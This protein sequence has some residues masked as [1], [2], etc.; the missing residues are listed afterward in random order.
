MSILE[1]ISF[2]VYLNSQLHFALPDSIQLALGLAEKLDTKAAVTIV[3]NLPLFISSYFGGGKPEINTKEF[4]DGGVTSEVLDRVYVLLARFLAADQHRMKRFPES[5]RELEKFRG[6]VLAGANPAMLLQI[7]ETKNYLKRRR[8]IPGAMSEFDVNDLLTRLGELEKDNGILSEPKKRDGDRAFWPDMQTPSIPL[9]VFSD[10]LFSREVYIEHDPGTIH[11]IARQIEGSPDFEFWLAFKV[12][13]ARMEEGSLFAEIERIREGNLS[14]VSLDEYLNNTA[15]D[16]FLAD[17]KKLKQVLDDNSD[18]LKIFEREI[19]EPKGI[20]YSLSRSPVDKTLEA[21]YFADNPGH[22]TPPKQDV[23]RTYLEISLENIL[24]IFSA[25]LDNDPN[26]EKVFKE[27]FPDLLLLGNTEEYILQ[28]EYLKN[29]HWRRE[30]LNRIV[31]VQASI[32]LGGDRSFKQSLNDRGVLG[33][34]KQEDFSNKEKFFIFFSYLLDRIFASR[35]LNFIERLFNEKNE[36]EQTQDR[37]SVFISPSFFTQ[38]PDKTIYKL[39]SKEAN[40]G[41]VENGLL[42]LLQFFCKSENTFLGGQVCFDLRKIDFLDRSD[43][44]SSINK[45]ISEK[46]LGPWAKKIIAAKTGEEKIL[47]LEEMLT[48]F[49]RK[50]I[51]VRKDN[52]KALNL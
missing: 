19:F 35:K 6:K 38:I 51:F 4:I 13:S 43:L 47:I 41:T 2:V 22:E 24:E 17:L 7:A 12:V 36:Y 15:Q 26:L 1:I 30:F 3:P 18:R 44:G 52:L 14:E 16:G 50:F 48:D 29:K 32:I 49:S 28:S 37:K 33:F 45:H 46:Y 21:R 8:G 11:D 34:M 39:N 31:K 5:R 23:D 10:S 27:F 20:K 40:L 42:E 9:S 25:I